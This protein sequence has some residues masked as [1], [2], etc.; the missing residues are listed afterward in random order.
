MAVKDGHAIQLSRLLRSHWKTLAFAAVAVLCETAAHVFEPWPIKIVIDSVVQQKPM[1]HWA[2]ALATR[3]FA[4]DEFAILNFAV[5]SVAIGAVVGSAGAYA[6]KYLTTSISQQIA[7]DLRLTL[8]H[9]IQRLS[10]AE[11]DRARTGDL[12]TTVTD[13]VGAVQDFFNSALLGIA[14]N[15][16]MLAGMLAVMFWVDW[17]LSVIALAVAP[18]LFLV[19][20]VLTRRI[21]AASR[22]VRKRESE[23]LS[24][25][26][27][28]LG[29][30][31]VVKAFAREDFEDRRLEFGSRDNMKAALEARSMKATLAPTVDIIIAGGTCLVLGYGARL[32]LTGRISAGVLV[33]FVLYLGKMY[34]P[35]RDLAKMIDAISKAAVGYERIQSVLE[36]ESHVQ[37][38]PRARR[39]PRLKG[40]IDFEHVNFDYGD[41]AAVLQDVSFR[42]EPGQV[43]A[44][45]GVSGAGKTTIAS[46]IP[47]FYD[48][49]E[50]VVKID[51]VDIKR[52]T[53]KS[54]RDQMSFVLQDTMLWRGS[55]WDNIAYGN[56]RARRHEIQ[57]AARLANADEFIEAFADGYSTMVGERGVTLSG[58]QRQRIAIARAIIR[59]TPILILDEPTSSLDAMSEQTVI[60]ALDRLM[61]NRTS[62]VIAHHIVTIRRADVIFVL[63]DSVLV[64]QGTHEGLLGRK[65]AYAA[66]YNL[67]AT[68]APRGSR[69]G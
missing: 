41:G 63:Q 24:G 5:A 27:E 69:T 2:A 55:I 49:V 64:E 29:S 13:D 10:L 61:Q 42:I 32:A 54:L 38:Q 6:E 7:H 9:H 35:M 31:R 16:L 43:A 68:Q 23:L 66:F 3:L 50:G 67:Q 45:V 1:P 56:P 17:Q 48:P 59:N 30:I 36:I 57:R 52:Y 44:F 20:Y 22:A 25:V 47:R 46:L 53:L 28:V 12:V 58:G 14:V 37:D 51:G 60:E 40:R 21:K 19:V 18:A 62:V 11:H 39:A 26:S 34:K 4:N 65:G 15:V 8:Y 33:V